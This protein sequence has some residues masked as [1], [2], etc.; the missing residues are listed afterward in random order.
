MSEIQN[1]HGVSFRVDNPGSHQPENTQSESIVEPQVQFQASSQE[2]V[3]E[4]EKKEMYE[5]A[6]EQMNKVFQAINEN[7]VFKFHDDADQLYAELISLDT[8]EVIKTIPPEYLLEMKAKMKE[9]IGL[10]IDEKL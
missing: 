7:L 9:M 4:Q 1:I 5:Q 6:T 2:Q 3:T 10:F 8:K